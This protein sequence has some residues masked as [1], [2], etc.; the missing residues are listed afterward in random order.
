MNCTGMQKEL[1][2]VVHLCFSWFVAF[3]RF[4]VAEVSLLVSGFLFEFVFVY[5]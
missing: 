4:C 1:W 3:L 2:V 5:G